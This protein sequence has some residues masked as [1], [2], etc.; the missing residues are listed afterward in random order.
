MMRPNC[1]DLMSWTT[2]SHLHPSDEQRRMITVL[3][4]TWDRLESMGYKRPN[5]LEIQP[6]REITHEM[7]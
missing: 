5:L 6:I 1:S 2:F 7:P 4:E 3:R